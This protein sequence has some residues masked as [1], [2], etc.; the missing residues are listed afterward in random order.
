MT[1]KFDTLHESLMG[2]LKKLAA[3]TGM[4]EFAK[5]KKRWTELKHKV[6][7]MVNAREIDWRHVNRPAGQA[8][9]WR[10]GPNK[11]DDFGP[12]ILRVLQQLKSEM[13][14]IRKKVKLIGIDWYELDK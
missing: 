7:K 12:D 14:E 6:L 8:F 4:G 1:S 11:M 3:K 5:L 10:I 2:S 13:D 9:N